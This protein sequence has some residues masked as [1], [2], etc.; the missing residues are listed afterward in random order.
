[1]DSKDFELF[2][3]ENIQL[4][5]EFNR[6]FI[7]FKE[8]LAE[9]KDHISVS[10]EVVVNTEKSVTVENLNDITES[11][12]LLGKTLEQAIAENSYKPQPIEV[13]NIKEAQ[14]KDVKINNLNDIKAYFDS[15]TNAIKANQPIVN[16][17]KQDIV[18]PTDP[19]KPIAVRLSNGRQFYEAIVQAISGGTI[20][21][22]L[23]R[24]GG[25]TLAVSNADGSDVGG[26]SGSAGD[27]LP[28]NTA[29]TGTTNAQVTQ[30]VI[31]GKTTAGG[32]SYVDVKVTP[33]GA[34][35]TNGETGVL[36]TTDTRID[37]A[38]EDTLAQLLIE[39]QINN[40]A[41]AQRTDDT[42]TGTI[43]RGWTVPGTA[44]SAGAWRI[45]RIVET[46]GDFVMTF[47]DGNN[48]FDNIWDNRA[49]LSYS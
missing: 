12:E 25:T 3:N 20:P 16:I 40:G 34:I 47:A 15:V 13:A 27:I 18:F 6:N 46:S 26:G 29:P 5:K 45:T 37:P 43:Y 7:A 23:L 9:K 39:M 1:M 49:S 41:Y 24:N 38:T 11:V 36:D 2:A 33:S 4:L 30:A 21:T 42:G 22:S 17:T 32:G 28:L 8:I 35:S 31:H 10:G 48:N 14:S 44:P 19:K